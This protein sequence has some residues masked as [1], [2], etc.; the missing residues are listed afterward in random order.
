MELEQ[1]VKLARL[2]L[3]LAE[4]DREAVVAAYTAMGVRTKNMGEG[5]MIQK[6]LNSYARTEGTPGRKRGANG[7]PWLWKGHRL[8]P[9]EVDHKSS[10]NRENKTCPG[11]LSWR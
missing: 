1:R 9:F 10:R 7:P 6:M 3:A 11:F 2:I 5:Y 4:D 8:V